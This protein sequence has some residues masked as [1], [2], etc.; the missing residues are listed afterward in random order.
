MLLNVLQ[1]PT[2][3]L[4]IIVLIFSDLMGLQFLHMITNEGSWLDIGTSISHY[5]IMETTVFF[6]SILYGLGQILTETS[7]WTFVG[8]KNIVR[9]KNM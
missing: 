4:F 2:G 3:N 8:D 6:V 1:A 9:P 7:G 5:V